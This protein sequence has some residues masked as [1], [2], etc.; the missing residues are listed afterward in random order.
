[1]DSMS[2]Q[3]HYLAVDGDVDVVLRG[4][5]EWRKSA[6]R[7]TIVGEITSENI[8]YLLNRAYQLGRKE[9]SEDVRAAL[10]IR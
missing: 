1:M 10:G 5:E 2:N 3:T 9:Q 4:R 7:P 6:I 8:A